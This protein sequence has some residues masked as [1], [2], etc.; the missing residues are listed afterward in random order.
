MVKTILFLAALLSIHQP[1]FADEDL[2]ITGIP[3]VAVNSENTF[4]NFGGPSVKVES[5]GYFGGL[6]FF[7]S[8]RYNSSASEWTPIL[9]AGAYAGKENI[10]IIF[11]CYYY[12]SNWY[13]AVGLG[14]RF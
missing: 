3:S 13:G 2:K 7:P 14:Y 11:P 12:T 9:G 1:S 5:R 4:L 10:F 8:L 6:S